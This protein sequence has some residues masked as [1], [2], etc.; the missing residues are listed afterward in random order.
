MTARN[1]LSC[2]ARGK[3]HSLIKVNCAWGASGRKTARDHRHF[4]LKHPMHESVYTNLI[5]DSEFATAGN[6]PMETEAPKS[7]P[8][9]RLRRDG[10]SRHQRCR[11]PEARN[12]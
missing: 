7:H 5:S 2:R 6:R 3:A 12:C 8:D 9:N 1:V 10:E 11:G 4:A